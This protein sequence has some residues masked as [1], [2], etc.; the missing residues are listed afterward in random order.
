MKQRK[1][2]TTDCLCIQLSK[3][4]F[5]VLF[6]FLFQHTQVKNYLA[7]QTKVKQHEEEQKSPELWDR[8]LFDSFR[9]RHEHQA[10]SWILKWYC[11]WYCSSCILKRFMRRGRDLPPLTALP[12]SV[13]SKRAMKPI[14]LNTV[15]PAKKLVIQ[16]INETTMLSLK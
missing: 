9:K 16:L 15:K 8:Q 11:N 13:L 7:V 10:W 6:P 4:S 5:F 14:M 12:T 1:T 3:I 2:L